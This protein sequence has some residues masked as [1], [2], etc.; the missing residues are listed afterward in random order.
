MNELITSYNNYIRKLSKGCLVISELLREEKYVQALENIA[1]F[2][3]GINW[4]IQVRKELKNEIGIFQL[5][6][7]EIEGFLNEINEGLEIQDYV[8]VADLFE[9]ELAEYFK[10]PALIEG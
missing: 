7:K 8:L 3:E 4:I 6:L 1:N 9:Y 5:N 10:N 2:S